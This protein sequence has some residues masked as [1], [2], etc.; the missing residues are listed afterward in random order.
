MTKSKDE[1]FDLP[2]A[3]AIVSGSSHPVE[4]EIRR[5]ECPPRDGAAAGLPER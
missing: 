1:G 4:K 3:G 5:K 2:D